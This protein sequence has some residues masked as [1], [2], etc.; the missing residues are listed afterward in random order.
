M[1]VRGLLLLAATLLPAPSGG[2]DW[3]ARRIFDR[4]VGEG[5]RLS[6]DGTSIVLEDG[7]LFEDDGPAAGFSY[8]GNEEVLTE[9]TSIRKE[10]QI[11]DPRCRSATL[12]LGSA[13]AM[14]VTV[15]GTPVNLGAGVVTAKYWRAYRLDPALLQPGINRIVLQGPGKIWLARDDEYASGSRTRTHHPNR[16]AKSTDGGRTWVD[17]RLGTAGTTDGEYCV[18]LRLD[19]H[20]SSGELKLPVVDLGNLAERPW[21]SPLE[22]VCTA[23][24]LLQADADPACLLSLSVRTGPSPDLRGV[25]WKTVA[26]SELIGNPGG[27]YLQAAV[28]LSTSDPLKSPRLKGVRIEAASSMYPDWTTDLQAVELRNDEIVRTSIP[29]EYEP[30]SH[31]KLKTLRERHGLDDVVR[32]AKGEFDLIVRLAGWVSGR[33]QKMH[34]SESYPAWDAL[35]ILA[36]HPD[37]TPV[38]GFCQQYNVV[39]L[40]ACESFG[41][42][43]RAVSIGQGDSGG[44]IPGSGHEVVEIWSNEFRKWIYID[45][46]AGWYAVDQEEGTPLS[47]SELRLRQ[48]KALRDEPHRPIRVV[49]IAK[50]RHRWP[51]LKDWPPF[52]ELRLIPRSNFLEAEAPLPLNQGLRGWFWTGHH[53][54][55]DALA[56][57]SPTYSRHVHRGGDFDWSVNTVHILLEPLAE[58]GEF[59]AHLDT[60]TPGFD[61]FLCDVDGIGEKPVATGFVWKL[62]KGRNRLEVKSR[63]LAGRT[64]P[65]SRMTLESP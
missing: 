18:R 39:L 53:V 47:L 37:G 17:D 14:R 64:G 10:F 6:P 20:R 59:R 27:R 35:D 34:L 43:G 7:E 24:I 32:G 48:V 61:T 57:A 11:A 12:L 3:D 45:A 40:Q 60:E 1:S 13:D 31:P 29:F 19:R 65:A 50:T 56:P 33:W 28:T 30:F 49:E 41:L 5:V 25:S 62:H 26:P 38:G 4:S 42:V 15:N 16:S 9:S 36:P 23:R 55:S 46:N 52:L 58:A 21:G 51:G 22:A 8:K 44:R 63:N 54:W 2:L